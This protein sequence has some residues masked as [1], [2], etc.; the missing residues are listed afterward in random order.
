MLVGVSGVGKTSI[1]KAISGEM[2]D[3]AEYKKP[4]PTF[5]F[6]IKNIKFENH[7][8]NIWDIGGSDDQKY[9]WSSYVDEVDAI[10]YVIDG[11]N[12]EQLEESGVALLLF[13]EEPVI[14]NLV[15]IPLLILNNKSDDTD[16]MTN[17]KIIKDLGLR[18]IDSSGRTW[19][20]IQTSCKSGKGLV[21]SF[22]WMKKQ[23]VD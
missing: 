6:D 17:D 9:Y 7:T 15:D 8:F 2:M 4:I 16:S 5:G 19:S 13:L 23:I 18:D 3:T 1:I 12:E 22:S 10:V 11:S 21:Q 14:Q 20:I